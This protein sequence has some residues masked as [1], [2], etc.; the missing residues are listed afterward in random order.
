M[1][2]DMRKEGPGGRID[3][4]VC[5][6]DLET[7]LH[8]VS[9]GSRAQTSVCAEICT[10]SCNAICTASLPSPSDLSL[11]STSSSVGLRETL[12]PDCSS[13]HSCMAGD[14]P[15]TPL[16]VE[17]LAASS[18]VILESRSCSSSS[19]PT[20]LPN[21]EQPPSNSHPTLPTNFGLPTSGVD[22]V[23]GWS[24]PAVATPSLFQASRTTAVISA[25]LSIIWR[26]RAIG[27]LFCHLL[28][29][30]A[31]L[32]C[33]VCS[34]IMVVS[35]LKTISVIGRLMVTVY[36]AFN[37]VEDFV[38]DRVLPPRVKRFIYP[39]LWRPLFLVYSINCSLVFLRLLIGRPLLSGS[40]A[41][42]D[43]SGSIGR[44][45][46]RRHSSSGRV[47]SY[48]GNHVFSL[49]DFMDDSGVYPMLVGVLGMLATV[50]FNLFPLVLPFIVTAFLR[51]QNQPV[52]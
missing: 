39:V 37:K 11:T 42:F 18:R 52:R 50:A 26:I 31:M 12:F 51:R 33:H 49:D 27:A 14:V 41:I 7:K 28:Y 34:C 4:D 47:Y 10:S 43:E 40:L 13:S 46:G 36:W 22:T 19:R 15:D 17:Q 20:F 35:F 44:R 2:R 8:C 3:G 25:L 30:V 9:S 6:Q 21:G 29:Q 1:S 45:G 23:N 32:S 24:S 5:G 16:Y 38:Y 48:A